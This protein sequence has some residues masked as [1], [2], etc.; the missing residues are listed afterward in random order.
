MYAYT[1]EGVVTNGEGL[2]LALYTSDQG[3]DERITTKIEKGKFVFKGTTAYIKAA[4]IRFENTINKETRFMAL[5]VY[6]EPGTTTLKFE[7]AGEPSLYHFIEF[8][9][10]H[11]P[12]NK[13][14]RSFFSDYKKAIGD[15]PVWVSRDPDQAKDLQ[16]NVYPAVRSRILKVYDQYFEKDISEIHLYL[17]KHLTGQIRGPGMFEKNQLSKEEI[18]KVKAY[19][20]K[21][22]PAL[23]KNIDYQ[24]VKATIDRIHIDRPE[25][26]FADYEL[27]SINGEKKH[28]SE[29]VKKNRFTILCFWHAGC[30]RCRVFHKEINTEYESLK[31]H[32]IE[33]ISINVDESQVLWRKASTEDQIPWPNLYA[34]R[35]STIL[36]RYH[37]R[38]FPAKIVYD[39]NRKLIDINF[40]NKHELWDWVK[41]GMAHK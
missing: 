29:W 26:D 27:E 11:G 7:V 34:G 25:K 32:G 28:L 5:P 4:K 20:Q 40:K 41:N 23:S 1:I 37:V 15:K 8:E 16:R 39:R 21:L 18:D 10:I 33:L 30:A 22:D 35:A 17:L 38:G 12:E 19:F 14:M 2:T 9:V 36:A 24:I 6:T 31:E 13:F 3:I